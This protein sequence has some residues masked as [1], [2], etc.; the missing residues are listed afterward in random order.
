MHGDI[1]TGVPEGF[2][3]FATT[4]VCRYQGLVKLVDPAA[5]VSPENVA[6]F[7]VQGEC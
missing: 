1:I 7:T 2:L 3:E 4:D 6:V 5:P